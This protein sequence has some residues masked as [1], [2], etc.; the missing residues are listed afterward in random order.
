LGLII[1]LF[2]SKKG[3][4]FYSEKYKILIIGITK[5][6]TV[7]IENVKLNVDRKGLIHG[8]TKNGRPYSPSGF[9]QGIINHAR[10]S[11][12]RTVLGESGVLIPP[13]KIDTMA[14]E[15]IDLAKNQNRQDKLMQAS[16]VNAREFELD[17]VGKLWLDFFDR[18]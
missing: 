10:A 3:Y 2:F 11:D 12:F 16:L 14:K 13:F 15:V 9:P 6:G 4:M 7:S 18:E 1:S 5:T 8:I 17:N